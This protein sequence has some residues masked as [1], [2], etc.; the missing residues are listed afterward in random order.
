LLNFGD[1]P[2]AGVYN[3]TYGRMLLNFI[4]NNI[5][6]VF[7]YTPRNKVYVWLQKSPHA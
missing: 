4:Q 1:L 7:A 2:R 6:I 5:F 3:V